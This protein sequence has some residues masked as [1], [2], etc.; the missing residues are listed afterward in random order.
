MYKP[1]FPLTDYFDFRCPSYEYG[2][3]F[4]KVYL[5]FLPLLLT[6]AAYCVICSNVKKGTWLL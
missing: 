3:C 6:A 5:L 2:L 4:K 1:L